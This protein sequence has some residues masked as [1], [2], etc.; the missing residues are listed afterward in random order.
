VY[1]NTILTQLKNLPRADFKPKSGVIHRVPE[2]SSAPCKHPV[3]D[4]RLEA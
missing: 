1:I 2:Q 3:A 4:F